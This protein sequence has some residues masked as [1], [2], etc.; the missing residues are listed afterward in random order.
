[1]FS[2]YPSPVSFNTCVAYFA[3]LVVLFPIWPWLFSPQ[4]HTVPSSLKAI[5]CCTPTSI[6]LIP[7]KYVLLSIFTCVGSFIVSVEAFPNSPLPFA[8][9]VH[10]VPSSFNIA[11]N[12]VPET[13][14]GIALAPLDT[15]FIILCA[16]SPFSFFAI[17]VAV[18]LFLAVTLPLLSTV[19]TSLLE[20]A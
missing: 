18:P 15:T 10:T 8:P 6:F 19:N 3:T 12:V 2:K 14:T 4:L 17:T 20:L 13:V 11:V 1:M 7:V 5:T 16:I 9:V